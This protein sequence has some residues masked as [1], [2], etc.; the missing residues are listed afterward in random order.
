MKHINSSDSY[1][2]F[3][4][5]S[6]LRKFA[7]EIVIFGLLGVAISAV[8][9]TFAKSKYLARIYVEIPNVYILEGSQY[10]SKP[11]FE[12][13]GLNQWIVVPLELS[14]EIFEACE[15]DKGES[16]TKSL[17]DIF[18]FNII[19]SRHQNILE[20][21]VSSRDAEK[22]KS[23][24]MAGVDFFNLKQSDTWK[25]YQETLDHK[26]TQMK[27]C[28]DKVIAEGVDSKT[29]NASVLRKELSRHVI[30]KRL[31]SC[32]IELQ[33]LENVK[34]ETKKFQVPQIFAMQVSQIPPKPSKLSVYITGAIAGV[35]VGVGIAIFRRN[36]NAENF[37]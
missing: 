3:E 11:S 29:S 4:L 6:V 32:A 34:N 25:K 31:E 37:C 2:F 17:Q 27:L 15:L 7:K 12:Q 26:I 24:L 23:C 21:S 10:V 5:I 22:S 16:N 18:K 35:L 8:I 20:M 30:V 36:R 14:L 28:I 13:Q 33:A 1:D 19:S 9:M